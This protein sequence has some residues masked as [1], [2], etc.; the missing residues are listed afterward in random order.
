M[1]ADA[2]TIAVWALRDRAG[3]VTASLRRLCSEHEL[4]PADRA[5]TREL[6]LGVVRRQATLEAVCRAFQKQDRKLAS[7]LREI[8][9]VALYQ[10]LFLD[11]VPDFA[12]VNEA[13]QQASVGGRKGQGGFVNGLLRSVLRSLSET[14]SGAVPKTASAIPVG[15]DSW[16]Q[17]DRDVFADPQS[18]PAAYLA[19]AYSIPEELARRWLVS[20]NGKLSRAIAWA[21]HANTPAPLIARVNSVK[22]KI[23]D[24]L[25]ALAEDGADAVTHANGR[26]VVFK[27]YHDVTRLRAF[28]D[29]WIQ[30]Q[31]P[32]ATAVVEAADVRP[33]MKVMDFCAA[34]GTKTTHLAERMDNQGEILAVDV[35]EKKLERLRDNCTRMGVTI[36]TPATPDQIGQ[37]EPMSYDVVLADVPCSNTGV[38]SR[39]PEARWRFT[40]ESL[41]RLIHDQK[42]ILAM[43]AHFVRRGGQL[44]YSTCSL[45]PEEC[46]DIVEHVTGYLGLEQQAEQLTRPAGV[47]EP[48][49]WRDGGYYAIFRR[50]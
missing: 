23:P 5:L 8:L 18:D 42:A 11:R 39:R 36:V 27:A 46:H 2:R 3:N 40:T 50:P 35:S 31:D 33:G 12:A 20:T 41:S 24:V 14:A 37:T 45:E 13:V 47:G 44:I 9:L 29:G 15:A 4:S 16:R 43:S 34:P 25:A 22:A 32:T 21:V 10:I 28:R 7:P 17:L 38:L 48:H 19:G 26:S 6:A 49:R 30:P 1:T